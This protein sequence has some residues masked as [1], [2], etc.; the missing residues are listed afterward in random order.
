MVLIYDGQKKG[1]AHPGKVSSPSQGEHREKQS[2][3]RQLS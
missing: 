2:H 3:P 1:G